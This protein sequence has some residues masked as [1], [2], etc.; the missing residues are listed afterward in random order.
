MCVSASSPFFSCQ[1]NSAVGRNENVEKAKKSKLASLQSYQIRS[2]IERCWNSWAG[3]CTWVLCYFVLRMA[4]VTLW[5]TE[6]GHVEGVY[7]QVANNRNVT[8]VTMTAPIN[9]NEPQAGPILFHTVAN[10]L[11]RGKILVCPHP[12]FNLR[13]QKD[14][15]M[16]SSSDLVWKAE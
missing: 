10:K 8:A 2:C 13:G 12:R 16:P 5:M 9:I 6:E 3:D 14:I 7:L 1:I 11:R 4:R 15:A